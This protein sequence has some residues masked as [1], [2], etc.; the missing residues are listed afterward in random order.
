MVVGVQMTMS[1]SRR[2][3]VTLLLAVGGSPST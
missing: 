3:A 1:D 2:A